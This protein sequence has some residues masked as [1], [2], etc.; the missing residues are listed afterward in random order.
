MSSIDQRIRELFDRHT[1]GS[2]STAER[3]EFYN[4][5]VQYP[6]ALAG[7]TN[8]IR[9]N[10][11]PTTHSMDA[12]DQALILE[13]ILAVEQPAPATEKPVRP[14]FYV[15]RWWAAAAIL[16]L[17]AAGAYLW[18]SN[19][20][21]TAPDSLVIKTEEIAPG[22]EGAILT[23]ADGR[24]VVL[25][26]LGNG[27]I[28]M[29]NGAQV[30][31]QDGLLAYTPTKAAEGNTVFNTM[32]T[33]KGRQ[34]NFRLPDGTRVWLNA[35]S[36]L[37]YPTVFTGDQRQVEVSGEAYFEVERNVK[38]PF[39]VNVNGQAQIKVLG[40][41][42][43]VNAYENEA[44]I[45][46][47][48]IEGSVKVMPAGVYEQQASVVLK[49]GQQAQLP[50]GNTDQPAIKQARQ[51]I[52]VVPANI[53]NVMAWKNGL[54]NFQGRKLEE[55]MRQLE[56]WYDIEVVYT[57]NI[58]DISFEGEMSTDLSLQQILIILERSDIHCRLEGRQLIVQP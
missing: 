57:K 35:A 3:K 41:S 9:L 46:T 21:N 55:V 43:N 58:P 34:F 11:L 4:L 19:K 56:R 22:K 13:S 39:R 8:D 40:T 30:V 12:E 53:D 28:A 5:L 54:F 15:R 26:S 36:S 52:T 47:T 37:R 2:L 10:D 44:R 24:Q 29:Q 6:D 51:G 14:V 49:P 38:M 27:V 23:L 32:T 50:A 45:N 48:L 1:A 42:F 18:T 31:L 20:N 25:D 7:L 33:P 16:L 17:L